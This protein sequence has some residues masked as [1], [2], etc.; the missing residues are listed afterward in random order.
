MHDVFVAFLVT[1]V[2]VLVIFQVPQGMK[3][4]NIRNGFIVAVVF[5]II[6]ALSYPVL[7]AIGLPTDL[8]PFEF[9][10]LILN[11]VL[12]AVV[13]FLVPGFKLRWGIWTVVGCALVLSLIETIIF[14]V[15]NLEPTVF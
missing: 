3:V 1:L 2:A 10:S 15:L 13:G 14:N 7:I 4:D 12:M 9:F 6:D 11:A 8:V 5:A